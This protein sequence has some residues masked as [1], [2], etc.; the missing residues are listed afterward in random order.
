MPSGRRSGKTERF[1]RFISKKAGINENRKYFAAAPTRDQA[2]R[3]F[4]DDLKLLTFSSTHIKPPSESEL[5]IFMNTGSTISVLG[6]D[7]PQRIE[8]TDWDGGGVDE[9]ADLKPEAVNENIM[10]ALNTINPQRP[11]HRP[12]CWFLGVPDGLNHYYDMAQLAES[13]KDS[14]YALFHWKSS[15]ILPPDVIEKARASM[16]LRQFK[17]EYEAS[18]E[19]ASGRI[20]EDYGPDN[21]TNETIQKHE[22]LLWYHD[23]NFTPLSSGIGV[24]RGDD[25]Y[26]LEEIILTSAVARQ[27]AMEFVERYKNHDNKHV[28]IY[29]DPAGKAGEKHGHASDYT[30]IEAV[31]REH[32]W[33]YMRK[34]KRSTRSI[35]DGQNAVRAKIRNAKDKVSLYVN[36][37]K[38]KYTHKA[39]ATC[40]LKKGSTFLEADSEYQHIATA[41]RYFI[42]FDFPV[43]SITGFS[44]IPSAA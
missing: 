2:K 15:E 42:D 32:G 13:G 4:W 35:K 14:D 6:L 38:A 43:N 25:V 17:Q 26:L 21:Y 40:E 18:F 23:F 11:D 29:G 9:I 27:S 37:D 10:P 19:T 39:L 28:I 3:I 1:K 24:R 22:Q 12:W 34:V 30:E 41:I 31:L 16:S 7:K 36:P 8:G 33:T 44:G 5:K 20:Y